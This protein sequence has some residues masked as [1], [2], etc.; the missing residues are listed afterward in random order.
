MT[1]PTARITP[2]EVQAAY[3]KTG[4]QPAKESY[5]NIVDEV[6]TACGIGAMA[7]A[8][9]ADGRSFNPRVWATK[10]YGEYYHRGFVAG[11]DDKREP[12]V[13]GD[14]YALGYADGRAAAKAIS[15]SLK[16]TA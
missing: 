14:R 15:F 1:E 11:F 12:A 7:H 2:E 10:K 13:Q 16:E 8:A 6:E 5:F 3:E 4:I 9:H